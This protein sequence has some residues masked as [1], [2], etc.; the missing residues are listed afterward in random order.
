MQ[1]VLPKAMAAPKG[2]YSHGIVHQGL[3]YTA[4]Q[5]PLDH[6]GKAVLGSIE[7]QTALC[8]QNLAIVLAEA[9]SSLHRLLRVTVYISDVA[10]WPQVD[11]TYA[12][13][14]GTHQPAR[15]VVPCSTLHYGCLIE[16]DAIGAVGG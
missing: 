13:V 2:H 1:P 3:V 7:E 9:G 8:L 11:A 4:G 16:M 14:L 15:T 5:L 10:L 12:K 6:Q